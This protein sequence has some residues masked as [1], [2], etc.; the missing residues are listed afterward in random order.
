MEQRYFLP[1]SPLGIEDR[2]NGVGDC[3]YLWELFSHV[4]GDRELLAGPLIPSAEFDFDLGSDVGCVLKSVWIGE[5]QRRF[6]ASFRGR[7]K[8]PSGLPNDGFKPC[9]LYT[10]DAADE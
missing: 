6:L 2:N 4:G 7:L 10:S 9:L 5:Q 1:K 8:L 3:E